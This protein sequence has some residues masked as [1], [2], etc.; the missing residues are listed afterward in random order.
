MAKG[1][2]G[3]Y[4]PFGAVWT[5]KEVNEFYDENVLSCGLTSYAHP[6]GLAAMETICDLIIAPQFLKQVKK[7]E[8]IVESFLVRWKKLSFVKETRSIGL[9]AALDTDKPLI[10]TFY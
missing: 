5:N 10:S 2:T 3:G 7:L 8:K 4:I 1:I 9:L 6:L